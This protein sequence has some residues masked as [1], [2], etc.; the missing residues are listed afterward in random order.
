MSLRLARN[1]TIALVLALIPGSS[2][3]LS[4]G[5]SH[6]NQFYY[7]P[8]PRT[9]ADPRLETERKASV[10]WE[11][12][13]GPQRRVVD[14]VCLVPDVPTFLEALSDWD[15]NHFFPILIDDSELSFK[16]LRAFRPARIVRFPGQGQSVASDK[17]WSRAVNAVANSWVRSSVG[18]RRKFRGDAVPKDLGPTPPG[19]VV[20][21]PGSVTLAGAVALAA[22][23]FQPL[24]RWEPGRRLGDRLEQ[25]EALRL[26]HDLEAR[27]GDRIP[28]DGV[29]GDDCDFIT[30]AGDYPYRYRTPS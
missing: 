4:P 15:D 7:W 3:E 11:V 23:R 1:A 5:L 8:P 29:L 14:L 2:A 12:R 24:L 22:G 20:S 26:V 17:L 21:E 9:L 6:P 18:E 19:V 30:L 25:E 13:T 16:F 27:I 10:S 28:H